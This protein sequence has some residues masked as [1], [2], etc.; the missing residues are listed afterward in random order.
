[1]KC[2]VVKESLSIEENE[3][4]RK[5]DFKITAATNQS[6]NIGDQDRF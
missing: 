2:V 1:M 3:Q 6:M 5:I 4:S